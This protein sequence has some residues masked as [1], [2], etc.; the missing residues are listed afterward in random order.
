MRALRVVTLIAPAASL[1]RPGLGD[2]ML[3][4]HLVVLL[5]VVCVVVLWRM[6]VPLALGRCCVLPH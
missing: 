2:H 4:A 5:L 1:H 3:W 6:R